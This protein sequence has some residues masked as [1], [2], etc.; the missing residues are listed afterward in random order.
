MTDKINNF[1]TRANKIH[2]NFYDYSLVSF[3]TLKDSINIIC[4][5]H[6]QFTIKRA[7][8]HIADSRLQKCPDCT[9]YACDVTR[10][11]NKYF[12]EK[13]YLVHGDKYD[14][15][16]VDYKNVHEYVK[17]ICPVENHGVF[18]Q[19]PS[20]H[21]KYGCEKCGRVVSVEKTKGK[22]SA[23]TS[24][25]FEEIAKGRICYFYVLKCT[26]DTELFYKIGITSRDVKTRYTKKTDMPYTYKVLHLIS[27][28]AKE[29]WKLENIN[30][31]VLKSKY[32]PSIEFKG[33]LTECYSD[34]QGLLLEHPVEL[35]G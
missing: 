1:I 13:A 12:L 33:S 21:Y 23:F 5:L 11:N 29:I 7:I 3:D 15:S 8:N 16:L 24:K 30:K 19:T 10:K 6:G 18:L 20:N 22:T 35:S 27:G 2:D 31:N 9:K 34:L 32:L 26:N 25:G 14:Y 17:I 28:S 4:P